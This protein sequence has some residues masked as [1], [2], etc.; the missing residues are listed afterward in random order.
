MKKLLAVGLY[1]LFYKIGLAGV[2]PGVQAWGLPGGKNEGEKVS[3]NENFDSTQVG[4]FT[5]DLVVEFIKY[6]AI[7]AVISLMLAGIMYI[8]SGGEEE[9]IKKAKSWVIWS[10]VG[11]FISISAWGIVKFISQ[12]YI[13]K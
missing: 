1:F 7:I 2:G 6:I 12:L 10:L 9:K 8:L 13:V 4:K 3:I 11:V 5:V